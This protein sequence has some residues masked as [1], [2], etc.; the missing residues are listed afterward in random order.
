ML[1]AACSS[2]APTLATQGAL[3]EAVPEQPVRLGDAPARQAIFS[4]DGRL[5]ALSNAAGRVLVRSVADGATLREI[6]HEGGATAVAF[7]PDAGRLFTAG[8]DGSVR[9]WRI[10]GRL[11]GALRGA[12]GTVWSIDL[13]PD[14]TRLAAAGEDRLIRIW[15]LG[16][17]TAPMVL[18]GHERNVW[19][20][21]FSPDGRR[22]ASGSF[23]ATARIWDAG[24]GRP[25]RVLRG[26]SEAIVGLDFSPDGRLIATGGDDS[27]I[28][29]W[30]TE[31][32]ALV[33]TITSDRHVHKLD[34]SADGRWIASAGRA[35]AGLAWFWHAVT[36]A[37]GD[38]TPVN[39]WRVADGARVQALPHPED[40][41]YVALAPDG[42]R[43]VSSGE[44]GIVR[45]WQLREE[46][47]R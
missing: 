22:I 11:L 32:G 36:G 9:I 30:R 5:L 17:G 28:R 35:R 47:A 4:G 33:R 24:T 6:A 2:G 3:V 13:S 43:L 15:T 18:R 39:L 42:R 7:S 16:S 41:M 40:V 19:E 26:H 14:G 34:F 25:L 8:Y 21:R 31:D 38:A 20:V 45:L 23:D 10:D 1:A 37:G 29:L 12:Q 27:A 44:D 46:R